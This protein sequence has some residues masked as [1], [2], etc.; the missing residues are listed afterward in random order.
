MCVV[1]AFVRI[2]NGAQNHKLSLFKAVTRKLKEFVEKLDQSQLTI[3]SDENITGSSV[4]EG[5][6]VVQ[7]P[8]VSKRSVANWT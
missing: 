6:E 8:T 1:G 4:C 7:V 3:S 2:T 5:C